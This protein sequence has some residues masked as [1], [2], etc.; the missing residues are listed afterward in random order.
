MKHSLYVLVCGLSVVVRTQTLSCRVAAGVFMK[1]IFF[2]TSLSTLKTQLHGLC[3]SLCRSSLKPNTGTRSHLPGMAQ[4]PSTIPVPCSH[5]TE[6]GQ[7]VVIEG[8]A[9]APGLWCLHNFRTCWRTADGERTSRHSIKVHLHP[10][11][12]PRGH[13]VSWAMTFHKPGRPPPSTPLALPLPFRG[14]GFSGTMQWIPVIRTGA[15]QRSSEW[16][17]RNCCNEGVSESGVRKKKQQPI[18]RQMRWQW[19]RHTN[20][21]VGAFPGCWCLRSEDWWS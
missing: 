4:M 21:S 16:A 5:K 2:L 10:F 6:V 15:N 17:K 8:G 19:W 20:G 11:D 14:F 13:I 3:F 1:L 9:T 12:Q 7:E 18:N